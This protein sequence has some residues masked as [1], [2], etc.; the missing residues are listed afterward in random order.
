[1]GI[2]LP[3]FNE[4]KPWGVR[5]RAKAF[6]G[7]LYDLPHRGRR[8]EPYGF[9]HLAECGVIGR[10]A[11]DLGPGV[12]EECCE[13]SL[14]GLRSLRQRRRSRCLGRRQGASQVRGNGCGGFAAYGDKNAIDIRPE[15]PIPSAFCVT[16]LA[17]EPETNDLLDRFS[18]F[19]FELARQREGGLDLNED[20]S[21]PVGF[22]QDIVDGGFCFKA[23]GPDARASQSQAIIDRTLRKELAREHRAKLGRKRDAGR[24][25]VA[26]APGKKSIVSRTRLV[27]CHEGACEARDISTK[28]SRAGML[29]SRGQ[30]SRLWKE[31]VARNNCLEH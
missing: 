2:R 25:R 7:R 24:R 3:R 14:R 31:H 20:I 12:F 16:A 30:H 22:D 17:G 5:R 4:I 18:E 15:R 28:T 10:R 29:A 19:A 1:V 13:S 27:A 8:S 9:Q 23:K 21:A 6:P 26:A 11:L